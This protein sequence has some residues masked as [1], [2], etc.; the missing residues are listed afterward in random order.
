MNGLHGSGSIGVIGLCGQSIFFALPHLPAAGETVHAQTVMQEPGGKGYNQVC[1]IAAMGVECFFAARVGRDAWGEVCREELKKRSVTPLFYLDDSLPTAIASICTSA[2]G[3][4]HVVVCAGAAGRLCP[5]DLEALLTPQALAGC[6]M[7]LMQL[8]VDVHCLEYVLDI[9]EKHGIPVLLNPAPAQALPPGLLQRFCVVT[10]NEGE[11]H[12]LL[13]EAPGVHLSDE[14][15]CQG[16]HRLGISKAV[17]T[18][19]ERGALVCVDGTCRLLPACAALH[20][21]DTTG[22]GD[23]FNAALATGLVEGLSFLAASALAVVAS[24][25]STQRCGVLAAIPTRREVEERM[26][27]YCMQHGIGE[28]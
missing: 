18:L 19:G 16:L 1:A 4:N 10:P 25:L 26:A 7:L 22:A 8:E 14:Q 5:A 2:E 27:A 3:E 23:V 11:A 13:G 17:I 15:L 20:V 6:S 9:G 21:M 12:M 24:G 28:N